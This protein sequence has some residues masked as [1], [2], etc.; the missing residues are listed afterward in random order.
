M[1]DPVRDGAWPGRAPGP[2]RCQVD[3]ALLRRYVDGSLA[4]SAAG[5]MDV[6]VAGCATCQD[7][8]G[9]LSLA[10]PTRREIHEASWSRL[11]LETEP[12]PRGWEL[13]LV[14]LGVPPH[15]ATLVAA[16]PPL[17]AAWLAAL[18]A[19]LGLSIVTTWLTDSGVGVLTFVLVAP[20]APVLGVA[21][22]YGAAAEPVGEIA[23]VAPYSAFKVV[24]LRA[25]AVV[26]ASIV[27]TALMSLLLPASANELLVWLVPSVAT[28]AVT[29]ALGTVVPIAQAAGL[30]F[31]AWLAVS[32]WTL[33]AVNRRLRPH[34]M[35]MSIPFATPGAQAVLGG[36]T[37]ASIAIIVVRR[38][39]LTRWVGGA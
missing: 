3:P 12:R 11:R 37:A 33:T 18:V 2:R 19:V 27:P 29:F 34:E 23:R 15:L 31:L 25:G 24:A 1:S 13:L 10:E 21:L 8:I 5:T 9:A 26:V 14:R 7:A 32:G 4:G 6:H 38:T 22:T 35:L 30:T 28:I 39:A 17:R 20:I 16:A 36:L